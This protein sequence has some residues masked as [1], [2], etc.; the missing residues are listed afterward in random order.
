MKTE[1]QLEWQT[2]GLKLLNN[3]ARVPMLCHLYN[4]LRIVDSKAPVW[5]DMELLIR[6]QSPGAVF[7]GGRPQTLVQ[8]RNSFLLSIGMSATS[9]AKDSRGMRLR[10]GN[11]VLRQYEQGPIARN[12]FYRW[13]GRETRKTNEA[14]YQL[15]E[16]L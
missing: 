8:A 5:P 11:T 12:L 4:A 10:K 7:T 9:L 1:F 2:L 16:L 15:Q 6:N 3:T 14:A 13:M